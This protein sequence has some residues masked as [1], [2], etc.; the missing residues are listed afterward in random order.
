MIKLLGRSKC[1][2]VSYVILSL[3]TLSMLLPRAYA[4]AGQVEF[5]PSADTYTDTWNLFTNYGGQHY[6]K[7]SFSEYGP[8][9]VWLKFNMSHVPDGAIVDN[10][11]LK[12]FPTAVGVTHSVSVHCCSNDSWNEYTI[13]FDNQPSYGGAEDTTLV[14][15]PNK[16]YSW[17]VTGAVREALNESNT[18]GMLTLVLDEYRYDY[19]PD[20]LQIISREYGARVTLYVH[21][22]DVILEFP[23]LVSTLVICLLLTVIV[24]KIRSKIS[25]K[26]GF[27]FHHE[28]NLNN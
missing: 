10:A 6:L 11:T 9:T 17:N 26:K 19:S 16:W 25:A 8:Q 21:W 27:G 3:F 2:S 5:V 14:S 13:N 15:M 24:A 28:R 1:L 4:A 18:S 22:T 20:Q 7:I 12:I 23:T